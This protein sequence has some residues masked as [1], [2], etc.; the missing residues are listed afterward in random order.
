M[1]KIGRGEKKPK[2]NDDEYVDRYHGWVLVSPPKY[3]PDLFEP[4]SLYD[5]IQSLFN[6]VLIGSYYFLTTCRPK[7]TGEI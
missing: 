1:G 7:T 5:G 2:E 3:A 4:T 6:G